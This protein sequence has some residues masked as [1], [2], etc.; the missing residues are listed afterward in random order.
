MKTR[1]SS[2]KRRTG[3]GASSNTLFHFTASFPNLLSILR[4]E[5]RPNFS[6]ERIPPPLKGLS[7]LVAAIPMVSFCDIPLSSAHYHLDVYGCYGIGLSK[8]WGLKHG[9][10]PVLYTYAAAET[11]SPAFRIG[12]LLR[13]FQ[14]LTKQVHATQLR[15]AIENDL[16][17]L[18][19]FMK[20]YEGTLRRPGKRPRRV[21]FYDERE[22]RFVPLTD[23]EWLPDGSL[24]EESYKNEAVRAAA[25]SQLA[26]RHVLGF[27]PWDIRYVIVKRESEILPTIRAIEDIKAKYTDDEKKILASRVISADQ[28]RED[29]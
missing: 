6:L 29:F 24:S 5:F 10:S 1:P 27:E 19:S 23:P 17:R 4:H 13:R 2:K 25:Q 15:A 22:W 21:R 12:I 9:I 18:I 11:A 28:V 14:Q 16:D 26:E 20:P 3:T 8:P 7:P